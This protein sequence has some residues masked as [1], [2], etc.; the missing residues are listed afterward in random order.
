MD[1]G[2]VT[3]PLF[4][5]ILDNDA[6][7]RGLGDSEARVLVEWLVA[8]AEILAEKHPEP[9]RAA[10][11]VAR[12]C[13]RA[14]SICRFVILWCYRESWGAACQFAATERFSWPLPTT[15]MDPCEL[16][17]DILAWEVELAAA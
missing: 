10:A 9:V 7:T 17:E 15:A 11:E 12:L 5:P 16:M 4:R 2:M 8:E 14:R 13:Q 3:T 1:V 6:L